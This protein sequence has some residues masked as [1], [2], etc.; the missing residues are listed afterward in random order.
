MSRYLCLYYGISPVEPL[1]GGA[2][3]FM[4]ANEVEKML[5]SIEERGFRPHPGEQGN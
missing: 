5:R 1:D 3:W 4:F 2:N